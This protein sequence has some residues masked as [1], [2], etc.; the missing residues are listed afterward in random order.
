[1]TE[2]DFLR[3]L[4]QPLQ[5]NMPVT[6]VR[7]IVVHGD[8]LAVATH[9]RGF[10]V[11]DR[12]SALRQ[13]A[14]E[15]TKIVSSSAYLFKPGTTYAMRPGGMNGTPLPHEE[16]QMEN[17]PAGVLV[18]YWL[19]S[20]AAKPL[21]LELIDGFLLARCTPARRATR[22]CGRRIPKR[23][24]CKLS[25][26]SRP[27]SR[28]PPPGCTASRSAGPSGAVPSGVPGA[29]STATSDA[30]SGVTVVSGGGG[31]RRG[32]SGLPPGNIRCV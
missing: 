1:M 5:N 19:Q 2:Q 11:M 32:G 13:I 10:W 14:A 17:P 3:I 28:R 4:R 16:P 29:T 8:D 21:K 12:M 22:P 27:N 26:C 9:G 20:D 15:G 18:Y 7:D 24:A 30:C 6:S 25:R 31:G 23:S